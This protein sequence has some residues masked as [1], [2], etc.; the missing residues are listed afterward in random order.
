V[1]ERIDC[2]HCEG[3]GHLDGER[4][5]V[6]ESLGTVEVQEPLRVDLTTEQR[7]LLH[8]LV[9]YRRQ[10]LYEAADAVYARGV[11]QPDHA[12]DHYEDASA[13]LRRLADA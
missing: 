12:F 13:L 10:V 9:A 11:E 6:C 4:C 8:Q 1:S 5:P 7:E 2:E 3:N